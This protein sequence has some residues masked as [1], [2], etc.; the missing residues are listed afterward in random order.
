MSRVTSTTSGPDGVNTTL[1][2]VYSY[3]GSSGDRARTTYLTR[4]FVDGSIINTSTTSGQA[5]APAVTSNPP[6]SISTTGQASDGGGSQTTQTAPDSSASS[7]PAAAVP[8]Q[9]GGFSGGSLAGAAI[10]CL[11]GG[12]LIAFL[13]AFL[14]FRKRAQRNASAGA[15][16]GGGGYHQ[17]NDS[18]NQRDVV[19]LSEKPSSK[20]AGAVVGWQSFLPQS[21]D[22]RTIQ[23]GVKTFF[24]L[25]ELHVDNFYRKA[26]VELDQR[27]REA[28]ARI[29]SGKLPG[30]IDQMMQDQRLVLPV[31][32]HCIADLLI[33]R[34]SPLTYPETSLLPSNLSAI[35]GRLQSAS[36]SSSERSGK[37]ILLHNKSM[38]A[39]ANASF[40]SCHPS[41][42]SMA[43]S[44]LLPLSTPRR[45]PSLHR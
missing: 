6:G 31:I 15:G 2:Y 38:C 32:K 29:D 22:D 24:N 37:C 30:R 5:S 45:R 3:T 40:C 20:S 39:C 34:M 18:T 35:P 27:T 4:T 25:I 23:N 44:Q 33:T 10:G 13:I 43:T 19:A 17:N 8:A 7:E 36:L 16:A 11:I 41:L 1:V 21:A 9:S 28:L 26:P 42:Q 14:I 12:A